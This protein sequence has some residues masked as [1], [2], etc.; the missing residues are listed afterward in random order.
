VPDL[1]R[2]L[3]DEVPLVFHSAVQ[4]LGEIGPDARDAV[5]ALLALWEEFAEGPDAETLALQLW[6][7]ENLG[8]IGPGARQA[9]P[10][11]IDALSDLGPPVRG[12]AAHALGRI[13]H[14]ARAA[15]PALRERLEDEDVAVA[16]QAAVALFRIDPAQADVCRTRLRLILDDADPRGR[17]VA[18][19]DLAELG[20][21]A[22]PFLPL[23]L[24]ALKDQVA[25]VRKAAAAALFAVDAD[26]ARKAGLKP[27]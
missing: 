8:H 23:L 16:A 4:A 19:A 6:V 14:A 24:D 7:I 3:G 1:A 9:V 25:E 13:G 18:L 10:R 22:R 12:H 15:L 5:P 2:T 21:A 11:L 27:R 17:L 20:P 26:A